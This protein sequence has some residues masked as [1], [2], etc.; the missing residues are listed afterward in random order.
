MNWSGGMT[1]DERHLIRLCYVVFFEIQGGLDSGP[2]RAMSS[3]QLHGKN[4]V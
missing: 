3:V 1:I 4:A 2:S